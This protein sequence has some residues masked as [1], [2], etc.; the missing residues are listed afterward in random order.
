[1]KKLFDLLDRHV[2]RLMD[3]AWFRAVLV[4]G[5]VLIAL[6]AIIGV[7]AIGALV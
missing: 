2:D 1:M 7:I 4:I 3:R 6:F 5:G